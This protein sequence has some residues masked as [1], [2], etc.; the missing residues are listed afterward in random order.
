MRTCFPARRRRYWGTYELDWQGEHV[1][2]AP[3]WPRMTM[4]EAVKKHLGIDFMEIDDDAQAVAAAKAAG[5][6]MDGVEPTWGH[7]L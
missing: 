6:D 7:A 2:L 1:S 3:G 4:A 5:V